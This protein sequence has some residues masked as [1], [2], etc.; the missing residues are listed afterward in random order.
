MY[1]TDDMKI[2]KCVQKRNIPCVLSS[3]L[4]CLLSLESDVNWFGILLES[5]PET[6]ESKSL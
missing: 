6:T 5:V 3:F 2:Q 4:T 1:R